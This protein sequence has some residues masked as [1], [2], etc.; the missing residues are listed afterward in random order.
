MPTYW[1]ERDKV[2]LCF[3]R[4]PGAGRC[5]RAM[6]YPRSTAQTA[7]HPI[8]P[9]L[10]PFPVGLWSQLSPDIAFW[11]TGGAV[12]ATAS[13]WLLGDYGSRSCDIRVH[14]FFRQ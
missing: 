11:I 10:I 8:H 3:K 6:P 4:V 5:E 14:R 2:L 12:W 13:M 1:L 7:R 9:M